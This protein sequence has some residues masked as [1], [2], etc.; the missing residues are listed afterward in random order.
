MV[1]V[2][3][4]FFLY[5]LD[6]IFILAWI[7]L[8]CGGW[9][10]YFRIPSSTPGLYPLDV[11][12]TSPM[13]RLKL[14]PDTD[15]F[16]NRDGEI[17]PFEPRDLFCTEHIAI[18]EP[19]LC[20]RR[21]VRL[22]SSCSGLRGSPPAAGHVSLHRWGCVFSLGKEDPPVLWSR[23]RNNACNGPIRGYGTWQHSINQR[24]VDRDTSPPSQDQEK[25]VGM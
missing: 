11:S 6:T 10:V 8:W 14:S 20:C 21:T 9:P 23:S 3:N 1:E 12:S 22:W 18:P 16:P 2:R 13:W 25:T 7:V 5:F 15:Q 17:I 24:C 19:F 4:S